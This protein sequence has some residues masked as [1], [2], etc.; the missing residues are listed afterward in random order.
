M[1]DTK[2][3]AVDFPYHS[4]TGCALG[5]ISWSGPYLNSPGMPMHQRDSLGFVY[6]TRGVVEFESEHGLRRLSAGD[7]MVMPPGRSYRYQAPA[8]ESWDERYIKCDGPIVNEWV[9]RGLVSADDLV[10]HLLP[11]N[12][13][14]DRMIDV[15]GDVIAPDPDESL[16]QLGRLQVLLADM[17]LARRLGSAFADDRAWLRQAR[18]LLEATES[19]CRPDLQ[20]AAEAMAC[21]YHTFRRRFTH[22]A[23][24]GPAEYRL[25]SQINYARALIVQHPSLANKE[26]A[27]KCGFGDEFHF[28]KQFKRVAK[29]SPSEFRDHCR[30]GRG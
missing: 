1:N 3:P 12:Y 23:G 5:R 11:V 30:L 20:A 29:M 2:R 10:W 15:I 9:A 13:W 4:E 28:S 27:V 26:L 21:S 7:M 25:Q 24:I 14:S 18:R 17:R 19:Q 6:V 8:G 16:A 22:L